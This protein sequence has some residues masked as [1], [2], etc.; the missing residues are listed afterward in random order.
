MR[1]FHEPKKSKNT[2]ITMKILNLLLT[3]VFIFEI[4]AMRDFT[5]DIHYLNVT[6]SDTEFAK[7]YSYKLYDNKTISGEFMLKKNV[8]QFDVKINGFL[9]RKNNSPIKFMTFQLDGCK[10]MI[11][12]LKANV[13]KE[14]YTELRRVSNMPIKCP[15]LAN[16]LYEFKNATFNA[17]QFPLALP[18]V[19]WRIVADL[20]TAK[21]VRSN[22][23][24][25][26][27]VRLL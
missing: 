27:R 5:I 6:V 24:V 3:A 19:A 12:G 7:S 1:I 25:E 18:K 13:L 26:G 20:I 11:A 10:C 16:K 17:D 4:N 8:T 23:I 15:L 2:V 21:K 22:I 14:V 9:L